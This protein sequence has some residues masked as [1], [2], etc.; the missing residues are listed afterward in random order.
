MSDYTK[1]QSNLDNAIHFFTGGQVRTNARSLYARQLCDSLDKQDVLPQVFCYW[2]VFM[3][4][5]DAGPVLLERSSYLPNLANGEEFQWY[6]DH[7][8]KDAE[9]SMDYALQQ[10]YQRI[11]LGTPRMHFL[12]S[13]PGTAPPLFRVEECYKSYKD[14]DGWDP[15]QLEQYK[16]IINQYADAA[17]ED[18]IGC[19][20][21]APRVPNFIELL[22]SK[23]R[24]Y[25]L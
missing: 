3:K 24:K 11:Q 8:V 9:R 22:N 14:K 6:K 12:E 7:Y 15:R 17:Y 21:L 25:I 10:H 5:Q 4:I 18:L 19:P 16:G 1:T 20:A 13:S 2:V 23:N